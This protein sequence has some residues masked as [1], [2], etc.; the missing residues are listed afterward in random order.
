MDTHQLL[1]LSVIVLAVVHA[2]LSGC[3]LAKHET[4]TKEHLK[5]F[6]IISVVVCLLIAGL[7][8]Y[9]MKLF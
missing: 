5:M 1:M 3:V 4:L 8:G 2:I 6:L 7:S 9:C